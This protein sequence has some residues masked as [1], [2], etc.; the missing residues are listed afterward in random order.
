MHQTA[1]RHLFLI[2]ALLLTWSIDAVGIPVSSPR[3]KAIFTTLEKLF[4]FAVHPNKDAASIQ[5]SSASLSGTKHET[6]LL[7]K[8][9]VPLRLHSG[10]RLTY[11]LS[12][13]DKKSAPHKPLPAGTLFLTLSSESPSKPLMYLPLNPN[14]NGRGFLKVPGFSNTSMLAHIENP[15]GV[16]DIQIEIVNHPLNPDWGR[17][18]FRTLLKKLPDTSPTRASFRRTSGNRLRMREIPNAKGKIITLVRRHAYVQ[19][20]ESREEWTRIRLP[21]AKKGWVSGKFI[22]EIP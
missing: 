3:K 7:K 12:H 13:S 17:V 18:M 20:L 4:P 15:D 1:P 11:T 16:K 21:N 14:A 22:E 6:I 10:D 5:T 9:Q 8:A 19:V 2:V